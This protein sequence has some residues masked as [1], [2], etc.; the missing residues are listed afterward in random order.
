MAVAETAITETF[1]VIDLI[2]VLA[3]AVLGGV[4]AR[5]EGLDPVG[6]AVRRSPPAWAA[7]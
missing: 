5:R 1:R 6:F 4:L 2:G 7:G 3:N